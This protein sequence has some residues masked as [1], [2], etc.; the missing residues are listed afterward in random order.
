MTAKLVDIL[1]N[2]VITDDRHRIEA[3]INYLYGEYTTTRIVNF[4]KNA[5]ETIIP[6][7]NGYL[8]YARNT[9]EQTT[10][11]KD[12]GQIEDAKI[13]KGSSF[14]FSKRSPTHLIKLASFRARSIAAG[15]I[16][17]LFLNYK[18]VLTS[19]PSSSIVERLFMFTQSCFI[20]H[21]QFPWNVIH[22]SS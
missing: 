11:N 10:I 6:L 15:L 17:T 9:S 1:N 3:C 18:I 16:L 12:I 4:Y 19:L 13:V 5:N 8:K 14:S 2:E 21:Q 20:S 22:N 7:E